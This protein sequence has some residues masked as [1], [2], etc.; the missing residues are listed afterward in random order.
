MLILYIAALRRGKR[1]RRAVCRG[2]AAVTGKE[3]RL[4]KTKKRKRRGAP[5]VKIKLMFDY[6]AS[7]AM[8]QNMATDKSVYS[9][10]HEDA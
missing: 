7:T 3:N 2:E 9:E 10:R 5:S 4:M 8:T 6:A 1:E